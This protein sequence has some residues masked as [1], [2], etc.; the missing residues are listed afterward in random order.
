MIIYRP[1]RGSL[2][3]AMKESCEFENELEMK[4]YIVNEWCE[5]WKGIF[6]NLLFEIDDI[7]IDYDNVVS[8]ERNG[9]KDTMYVCVKRMDEEDYMAKYGVPQCIG[10]CATDYKK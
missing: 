8:D 2:E 3:D 6:N 4:K 5:M 7:V 10:M 1:H 9:W